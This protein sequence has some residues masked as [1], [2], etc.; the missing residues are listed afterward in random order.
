MLTINNEAAYI[1]DGVLE[2]TEAPYFIAGPCFNICDMSPDIA[3][4]IIE[5]FDAGKF[6]EYKNLNIYQYDIYRD[7]EEFKEG[8]AKLFF[9][10]IFKNQWFIEN[11]VAVVVFTD[12]FNTAVM[13]QVE[14]SQKT[15]SVTNEKWPQ[16][17][18]RFCG[19]ASL[20]DELWSTIS[21]SMV[22]GGPY[23]SLLLKTK[24]TDDYVEI[25]D[26]LDP[27]KDETIPGGKNI[28]HHFTHIKHTIVSSDTVRNVTNIY[29]PMTSNN[30]QNGG[31]ISFDIWKI[32]LEEDKYIPEM[33]DETSGGEDG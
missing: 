19:K 14:E 22:V 12:E 3:D 10:F 21:L 29:G 8:L 15:I 20:T 6:G 17:T 2:K 28:F 33:D 23:E 11:N 7:V 5:M 30:R 1:T 24:Q 32:I 4:E 27:E 25:K 31:A 13:E 16:A 26:E 18:E 9:Y